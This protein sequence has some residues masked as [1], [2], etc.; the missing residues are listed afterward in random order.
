M[1]IQSIQQHYFA[2]LTNLSLQ[3]PS[4]PSHCLSSDS[5]LFGERLNFTKPENY[6]QAVQHPSWQEAMDKELQALHLTLT[7]DIVSLPPGKKPI[8]CK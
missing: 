8:A 4:V 3:P 7:W 5:Q 1:F 6:E 2:T